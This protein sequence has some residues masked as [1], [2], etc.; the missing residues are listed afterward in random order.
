MLQGSSI[1]TIGILV[2]GGPAPGINGVIHSATIEAINSG[3]QVLGIYDGF[4]SLISGKANTVPL[5]ISEVSRI[6][7]QGGSIL[8]TS[9][10]NPTTSEKHLRAC[11]DAL[12][13]AGIT[14]L[15]G[16]GGD[17][18]AYSVR[19]VTEQAHKMGLDIRSVHVPKTI[20]NDLPLP[21]GI[22]TFG[23]ETAREL[24]THLVMNMM[25]DA[26]TNPGWF[27][28]VTM[29]RQAGHLALGIGKS[30]GA[31]VT[32]IAEEWRGEPIRLQHVVDILATSIIRRLAEGKGYGL[33]LI[34][35][36]IVEQLAEQ[37][38]GALD[39]AEIDEHGHV[40]LA[41]INFSDILKKRLA[42]T[43]REVGVKMRLVDKELGYELRCAPPVAYDIDY[44]ISLGQGAA[45]YLVQGGSGATVTIQNNQV[46]P[47]PYEEFI[48]PVTNRTKVRMVDVDSFSYRSA[49]KFMIRLKPHHAQDRMYLARLAAQTDLSTDKFIERFGYVMGMGQPPY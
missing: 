19:R 14:A 36:G 37:D 45:D 44:T 17:D 23:Y 25:D 6:H 41:E 34:A 31:T 49:E 9:R 15:I 13:D 10:A 30:A 18:T 20:D 21:E 2:G 24:G 8:R 40:R 5:T 46:V 3:W 32:V 47:V 38:R 27:L 12:L 11:V 16:I 39:G 42:R 33:A 43:L 35:E 28:V 48:D 1:P 26:L 4:K 7:R 29:G 22:P